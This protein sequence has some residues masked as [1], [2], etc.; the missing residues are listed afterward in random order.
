VKIQNA[1][2][3]TAQLFQITGLDNLVKLKQKASI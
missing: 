3:L 1:E 2:Q